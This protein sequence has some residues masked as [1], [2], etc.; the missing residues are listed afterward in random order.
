MIPLLFVGDGAR[1]AAML[2][3]IV[4]TILGKAVR[5]ESRNWA[6]L[7][8]AGRGYDRK[9][10]FAFAAAR[11]DGLAGVVATVDSDKTGRDRLAEMHAA[12]AR[13][14]TKNPALP[15]ALGCAEPHAEAWLLDDPTAIRAELNL[16][17]AH[18]LPSVRQ[19]N[20]PKAVLDEAMSATGT[21]RYLDR[22]AL[23]AGAL[24]PSRCGHKKDTG[25]GA[26]EQD[27]AAELGKL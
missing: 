7:H 5:P 9:L 27:V 14:R 10:L 4:S 21:S 16:P 24:V 6:R 2:P 17:A 13:D 11:A 1:D 26:F 3:P 15:A 8:A 12:R 25:F 18:S 19:S 20:N 22:I 23:V